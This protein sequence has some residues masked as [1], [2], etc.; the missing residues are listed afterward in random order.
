MWIRQTK[1]KYLQKQF[2]SIANIGVAYSIGVVL[3]KTKWM[4]LGYFLVEYPSFIVQ[5]VF[6]EC[7]LVLCELD[8]RLSHS[9]RGNLNG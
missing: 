9:G 3:K 5:E 7:C 4:H 2:K 6:G 8:K 1:A